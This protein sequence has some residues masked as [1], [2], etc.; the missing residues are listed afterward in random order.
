LLGNVSL[1]LEMS[2]WRN[3]NLRTIAVRTIIFKSL[4]RLHARSRL[5]KV[6]LATR[7]GYGTRTSQRQRN[8]NIIAHCLEQLSYFDLDPL[9]GVHLCDDDKLVAAKDVSDFH[10]DRSRPWPK[11]SA[12]TAVASRPL[13]LRM[14]QQGLLVQQNSCSSLSLLGRQPSSLVIRSRRLLLTRN[15]PLCDLVTVLSTVNYLVVLGGHISR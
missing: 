15:S 10:R 4:R 8:S 2:G 7:D 1:S 5:S 6:V 3:R 12:S 11:A 14:M 9:N 13:P